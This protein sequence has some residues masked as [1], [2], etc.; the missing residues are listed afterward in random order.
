MDF[1]YVDIYKNEFKDYSLNFFIKD[2]LSGFTVVAVALP[3]GLSYGITSGTGAISGLYSF[4]FGGII[5]AALSNVSFQVNGSTA[6]TLGILAS[7]TSMYGP[8]AVFLTGLISGIIILLCSILNFGKYINYTPNEIV[9]GLNS[10]ISILLIANQL[11]KL[12]GVTGIHG[13]SIEK[14]IFAFSNIRE[15][16]LISFGMGLCT[17]VILFL[18]PKKLNNMFP[19]SLSVIILFLTINIIFDL[20]IEIIGEIPKSILN[21]ISLNAN[22]IKFKNI[23]Y[24][25]APSFSIAFLLI[26][27]SISCGLASAKQKNEI[28]DSNRELFALGIGNIIL[29]FIGAIPT[30]ASISCT[31]VGI[32]NNQKTRISVLIHSIA[33]LF[34]I[35]FF[36]DYISKIP[37]TVLAGILITTGIKMNKVKILKEVFTNPKKH[38][39]FIIT[40]VTVLIKDVSLGI[41]L[42]LFSYY[43]LYKIRRDSFER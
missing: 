16:N 12:L 28:L 43:I 4:L 33:I 8:Q 40:T 25:I 23:L 32:M 15:A 3:L 13:S 9:L 14:I 31:Q 35:L 21:A 30:A 19:A 24:L 17:I 26:L 36:G 6:V 39:P 22:Y 37:L 34:I 5:I 7:L 42:G 41:V 18:Y 29:P 1:N 27:K 10:G 2:L 38:L 20:D 11:K